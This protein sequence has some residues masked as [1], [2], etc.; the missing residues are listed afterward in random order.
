MYGGAVPRPE[1]PLESEDSPLLSFAGDLRRLRMRAG[2]PAY[3]ELG[4]RTN[5]SAAALSEALSGRR[6]PSL[7]ITR[8][9]VLACGGD[10]DEWTG[11][12]RHLAAAQ[13]GAT[14]EV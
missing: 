4:K 3:R 13:P 1:R 6:L 11:R 5:Y 10:V 9:I 14:P 12:W 7:A 8:A 2:R